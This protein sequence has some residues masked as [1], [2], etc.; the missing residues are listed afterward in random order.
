MNNKLLN[1][2]A[3]LYICIPIII[4]LFGWCKTF[5]AIPLAILI[6]ISIVYRFI[7]YDK[8][9]KILLKEY[10]RNNY[11]KMIIIILIALFFVLMSGIGGYA[12]Q[13]D[14]HLYRNAIFDELVNNSWPI[15]HNPKGIFSSMAI[16]V[17]Y[18]ASWLPAALLAKW[19]GITLGYLFL[20]IWNVLGVMLVFNYIKKFFPNK[21]YLPII[22]FIL[23]S[24]LDIVAEFL[25]GGNVFDIIM[26]TKHIEWTTGYQMSSFTTQLFWVFNQALPAWII[27]LFMLNESDN[28]YIGVIVAMSLLFC[29]LPAV[30]LIFIFIYKVFFETLIDKRNKNIKEWLSYTLSWQNIIIGIPI[31]LISVLFLSSNSS[32]Q[33][34]GFGIKYYDIISVI[35]LYVLEFGLYYLFCYKYVE[36]KSLYYLSLISLIIC[37]IISI[38]YGRDFCMRGCIAGQI[39]MFTFV[40]KALYESFKNKDK[41]TLYI[42]VILL[43]FGAVTPVNEIK[44]T[45]SKTN[46]NMV[47]DKIDLISS[48]KATNF[49]GYKD[50]SLFVKYIAKN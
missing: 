24:G 37:P 25:Y 32:G 40:L 21:F 16:F 30:G 10:I 22:I 7:K 33:E 9:D 41:K 46:S 48:S 2:L 20:C 15:Y 8:K 27:T 44:R 34:I 4:F 35:V 26:S 3:Y 17:Y 49:Y 23:F 45:I 47:I 36:K 12:Y 28:K 43:C 19:L 29:T 1:N 39:V 6:V 5:I 38:G 11:K 31:L 50:N 14:D 18:F 13:N 42:L